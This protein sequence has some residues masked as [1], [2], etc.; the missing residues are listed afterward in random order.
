M[1]LQKVIL[2]NSPHLISDMLRKVFNKTKEIDLVSEVKDLAEFSDAAEQTDAGWAIVIRKGDGKV[3]DM[4]ERGMV[5]HPEMRFILMNM[6]GSQ[7][8][9][10]W[11]E[12]HEVHLDEI[13]LQELLALLIKG[14]P[15]RI[16]A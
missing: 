3:P 12:P 6:D 2:V 8:S 15:E 5:E 9:M 16:K 13:N 10:Q 14:Q 11:N 1:T 4:V 7:A